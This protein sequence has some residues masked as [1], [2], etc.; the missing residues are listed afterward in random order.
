[1]TR[2]S[3][4]GTWDGLQFN[5]TQR[6]NRLAF[7]DM[8]YGDGRGH[9]IGAN[10]SKLAIDN[11]TW[12]G[13]VNTIIE[14]QNPSLRVTNSV[15]PSVSGGES[16]HGTAPQGTTYLILEGN[17]F[18]FNSSGGDVIDIGPAEGAC[19]PCS[20]STTSSLAAATTAST[21]TQ[22]TRFGKATCS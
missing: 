13:T 17:T 3:V 2:V 8:S 15:F 22:W 7:V 14:L 4:T 1:M 20:S 21:S 6:D 16:L 11:A 12:S 18:G 9:S 5:S 10:T 19:R